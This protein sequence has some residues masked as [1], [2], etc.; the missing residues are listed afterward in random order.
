MDK[1]QNLKILK[2]ILF[3]TKYTKNPGYLNIFHM[4]SSK[5]LFDTKWLTYF[6]N[7]VIVNI[8]LL[9]NTFKVGLQ[10]QYLSVIEL[11]T[12]H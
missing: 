7:F 5:I 3:C 4:L 8:F 10:Y 9:E 12:Q 2:N 6:K 11:H 1:T